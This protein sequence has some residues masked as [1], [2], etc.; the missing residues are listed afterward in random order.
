MNINIDN[1]NPDDLRK[2]YEQVGKKLTKQQSKGDAIELAN[3]RAELEPRI[4]KC[5]DIEFPE[6]IRG[7]L[8]CQIEIGVIHNFDP[9]DLDRELREGCEPSISREYEV[10]VKF[11]KF[12][13][14]ED[15]LSD[16][17]DVIH[18]AV[19]EHLEYY[20]EA[21]EA[22]FPEQAKQFNEMMKEW[23]DTA[24]DVE[25]AINNLGIDSLDE[26]E[27]DASDD[28]DDD[29]EDEDDC[30]GSDDEDEDD[31]D[32]DEEDSRLEDDED[33]DWEDDDD[34]EED[35]D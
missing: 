2:L 21:W 9:S 4:K 8:N 24:N 23:N 25:A 16:I 28:E 12:S 29:D 31:E 6:T 17:A 20:N 18:D 32:D 15:S 5:L 33:D 1:L 3:A 30:C 26:V 11:I 35:D 22:I 19:F 27:N 13:G 34:E 7:K 14:D 10:A